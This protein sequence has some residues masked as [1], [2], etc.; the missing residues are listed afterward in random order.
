MKEEFAFEEEG[1]SS[2]EEMDVFD[3]AER[4]HKETLS[5]PIYPT[6]SSDQQQTVFNSLKNALEK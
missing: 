6:L 4:Y 1:S 2:T 5:L 3:A